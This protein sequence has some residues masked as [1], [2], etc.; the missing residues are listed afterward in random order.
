M[1]PPIQEPASLYSPANANRLKVA[2]Y[3]RVSTVSEKS[4]KQDPETQLFRLRDYALRQ[5][6]EIV[7]EYVD[8]VSGATASRPALDRMVK[9]ATDHRFHLILVCK[10]DRVGRSVLNLV[11]LLEEL[12]VYGVKL[13]CTDQ[14]EISTKGPMGR[15]LLHMLAAVAEYERELIRDRTLAGLDRARAEGKTFG[16][17]RLNVD[18]TQVLELLEQGKSY[19]E[20]A[21]QLKVSVGT[22]H[23]RSKK[24]RGDFPK[25]NS[26]KGH[27]QKSSDC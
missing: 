19:D 1:N 3:A 27:L 6:Y 17:P 5:D 25:E 10:I 14:P 24:E 15:L 7:D 20:V 26:S 18:T 12:E 2:L 9:D 4:E 16:R 21:E 13:L 22:V 8:R 11:N 23:S